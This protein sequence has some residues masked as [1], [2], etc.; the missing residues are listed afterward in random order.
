M[1]ACQSSDCE[2]LFSALNMHIQNRPMASLY[3]NL[4]FFFTGFQKQPPQ[5]P[6]RA[7][8]LAVQAA[9]ESENYLHSLFRLFKNWGYTLL[10]VTYGKLTLLLY[11]YIYIYIYIYWRA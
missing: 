7:Q 3:N 4:S 8:M 1:L 10:M 2:T 6:S 9:C 11:I 5:P